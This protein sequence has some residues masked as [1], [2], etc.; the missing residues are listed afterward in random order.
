MK[1]QEI[2]GN[3]FRVIRSEKTDDMVERHGHDC[4]GRKDLYEF[5]KNPSAKKRNVWN[6]WREWASENDC[7]ESMYVIGANCDTFSIGAYYVDVDTLEIIGYFYIT[8]TY[9]RLYLYK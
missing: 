5:Y 3:E 2:G 4:K 8:A 9:N 7:V 1:Y 6:K